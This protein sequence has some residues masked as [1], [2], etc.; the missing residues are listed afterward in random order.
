MTWQELAQR[1]SSLPKDR[2]HEQA[3]FLIVDD[4]GGTEGWIIDDIDQVTCV[5]YVLDS[6][7][8]NDTGNVEKDT[9]YVLTP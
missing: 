5:D 6:T 9:T 4:E 8:G 3:V 1:I 2:Q 7:A